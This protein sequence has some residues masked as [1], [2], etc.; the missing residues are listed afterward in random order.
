MNLTDK[1]SG[2]IIKHIIKIQDLIEKSFY[3]TEGCAV[4]LPSSGRKVILA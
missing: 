1:Y 3:L 4:D 2:L